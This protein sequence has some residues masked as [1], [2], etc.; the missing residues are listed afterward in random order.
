M[1][2]SWTGG[3]AVC[4]AWPALPHPR[5]TATNDCLP[6]SLRRWHHHGTNDS[7]PCLM[8]WLLPH[9][10]GAT[11]VLG[12]GAQRD[13]DELN[14]FPAGVSVGVGRSVNPTLPCSP[15]GAWCGLGISAGRWHSWAG[16][17]GGCNLG[18]ALLPAAPP[19]QSPLTSGSQTYFS[20][21]GPESAFQ[22][23]LTS[24]NEDSLSEQAC[25]CLVCGCPCGE[26][27]RGLG[28]PRATHPQ[29][30]H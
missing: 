3:G 7:L 14:T 10:L 21:H 25:L 30:S 15:E 4:Q 12:P 27:R 18:P 8:T 11:G 17:V 9:H 6:L 26:Q 13:V 29:E 28:Q 2:G 22:S 1:C 16:K 5:D 19:H 23:F 20:L 24:V